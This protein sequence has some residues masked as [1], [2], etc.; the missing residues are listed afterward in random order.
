M[1]NIMVASTLITIILGTLVCSY[2]LMDF[3]ITVQFV[4]APIYVIF[5]NGMVQYNVLLQFNVVWL[6]VGDLSLT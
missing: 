1:Y 4:L 6:C 3:S 5:Y 2:W